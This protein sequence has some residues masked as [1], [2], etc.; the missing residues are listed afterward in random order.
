MLGILD[1]DIKFLPGVGP[2]RAELLRKELNISTF[3]ELF[4][5]FPFRYID[6]TKFYTVKEVLGAQ[7]ELTY[8]QLRGK[9]LRFELVG[10]GR[11]KERYI[12]YFSDD[13]GTIE[14]VFFQGIKWQ[15]ERLK[16]GQEYIVFGRSTEF[17]GK[18]NMVHPEVDEPSED[19]TGLQS[20]MQGVYSSTEILRDN[21]LGQRAFMKL[22]ANLAQALSGKI[23][24]TLP[25]WL[26]TEQ[27]LISLSEALLNVHFPQSP[28]LME[29]AR[30]RLKFEELFYIQLSLLKQ[31]SV[32]LCASQGFVF[33]A[34]GEKFHQ[35]YEKL[36]FPLTN[37]QKRVIKE[38]RKDMGSGKQM[39]RLLQGDV[40]S[41]KTLVALLCAL[42]A[43]D[44]G[45]QAAI[46]APTE[47]LAQ[48]HYDSIRDFL[49]D[50]GI[51]VG[52]LTGS[53][54]K[55]DRKIL[56]EGLL[57]GSLHLL[58]GTHALIEDTVQ[59]NNL[60]FVVIDEQHRF[61]VEQRARLWSKSATP[62][63]VL[64][65]T[66]TPIPRTLAMTLYGDLDVSVIDELPPG[67]QPVKTLHFN[68]GKRLRVFGFMKEQ[69]KAGRQIYMVYPLIKESEKMDYKNLDDGYES[70]IRAFPP[71]EY[72]TAIVH[73][74]M[75]AENKAIDMR[76]F[77][78][79]KAHIM[80]AT[81]VIEVGVNVPNA[82]VMVIESAERFGLSQLHQLRG[83]VGRGAE[84]SF[85][86]LMTD[87]KLSKE[88]KKR[89]ELM[90]ST[91][92]G[93]DIAEADLQLRGPGDMEGTQ[94][95]GMPVNLHIADLARDG[96]M[97]EMARNVALTILN[98]DPELS[99][100]KN[101]LLCS[102]LKKLKASTADYSVIS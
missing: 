32:R 21:G 91:N 99:S 47:I 34:V 59:F 78:S 39:N 102:Q 49:E 26:V 14:L 40:G 86:I 19:K 18:I 13:T 101:A 100:E 72:V 89:M 66:A 79:G 55:K 6:R 20:A 44:N 85:C 81:S 96:Q 94:Q 88:A 71:P 5:T 30:F 41:G 77:V 42:I 15:R 68:D 10:K 92:N 61:G 70:I 28:A 98:T 37:A 83:R 12:A 7:T 31:R 90:C 87:Y 56:S 60:G 38:I 45:Y 54:K 1:Q 65:M 3:G 33:S 93:F 84:Q 8:I 82:S 64:V 27:H 80:V 76:R 62:P 25:P 52:L 22:Q 95:S 74:K 23:E 67:R 69:I 58:V 9:M 50:T 24:E 2:R 29:A 35:C 53:T 43:N 36:P 63:H 17:K 57:N 51:Q 46:M 11:G 75:T 4:Y 48:Q 16:Q 97:L 73:G